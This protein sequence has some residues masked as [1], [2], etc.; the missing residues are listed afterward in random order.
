MHSEVGH[1]Y[2]GE[3][4][5]TH[6]KLPK[7]LRKLLLL[8][9]WGIYKREVGVMGMKGLFHSTPRGNSRKRIN[10]SVLLHME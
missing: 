2:L 9:S 1:F 10:C 7:T 8:F 6:R 5:D 3:K 4:L